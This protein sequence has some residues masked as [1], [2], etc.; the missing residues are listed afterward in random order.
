NG[1]L[2]ESPDQHDKRSTRIAE[3]EKGRNV[4][5]D[6]MRDITVVSKIMCGQLNTSEKE[7][8]LVSLKKLNTFHHTVY[9]NFKNENTA[10]ILKLI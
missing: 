7:A 6:S 1:L 3:T 10:E 4:F 9:S 5:L 8:L 2:A